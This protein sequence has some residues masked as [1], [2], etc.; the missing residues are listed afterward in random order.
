M[1]GQEGILLAEIARLEG[2]SSDQ[3]FLLEEESLHVV[4]VGL[5]IGLP[6]LLRAHVLRFSQFEFCHPLFQF[7]DDGRVGLL[8][9]LKPLGVLLLSLPRVEPE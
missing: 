7:R 3:L 9:L 4:L 5:S 8:L 6:L 1:L 2:M